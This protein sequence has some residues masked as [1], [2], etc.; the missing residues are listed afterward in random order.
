M[1]NKERKEEIG[2]DWLSLLSFST[3]RK[4]KRK[5][6]KRKDEEHRKKKR[7]RENLQSH[8]SLNVA[9]IHWILHIAHWI[10]HTFMRTNN[11][12]VNNIF[13]AHDNFLHRR[14]LPWQHHALTGRHIHIQTYTKTPTPPH[15]HAHIHTHE[16][17]RTCKQTPKHKTQKNPKEKRK[18]R[19]EEKTKKKR[20]RDPRW[21]FPLFLFF[22]W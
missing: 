2:K 11:L 13:Y 5:K 21:V 12:C 7:K 22:L 3:M 14:E 15:T 1:K 20:S 18:K 8:C 16:H 9:H 19:I 6:K 4:K 17:T 10:L